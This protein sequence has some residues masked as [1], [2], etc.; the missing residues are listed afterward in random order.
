M[1]GNGTH[2]RRRTSYGEPCG[3]AHIDPLARLVAEVKS[4]PIGDA[5]I[6]KAYATVRLLMG[7]P[8]ALLDNYTIVR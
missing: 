5:R 8:T 6:E 7:A 3:R 1:V 2:S 4:T